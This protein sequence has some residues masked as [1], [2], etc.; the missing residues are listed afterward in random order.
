MG[1][2]LSLSH[3]REEHT[4]RVLRRT[5]GPKREEVT[6]GWRTLHNEE[7]HDVYASPYVVRMV[8]L[9]IM[10]GMGH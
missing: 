3:L 1:V 8:K 7:L 10:Y 5:F 4:V 6:G 9:R 2:E